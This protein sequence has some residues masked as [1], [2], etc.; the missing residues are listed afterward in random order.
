M[1]LNENI[2]IERERERERN[3]IYKKRNSRQGIRMF[4]ENLNIVFRFFFKFF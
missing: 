4:S 3:I 1:Q 2:K